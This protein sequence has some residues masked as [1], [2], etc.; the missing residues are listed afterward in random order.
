MFLTTE[1]VE[2]AFF[3]KN[4]LFVNTHFSMRAPISTYARKIPYFSYDPVEPIFTIR[5]RHAVLHLLL[6]AF[7]TISGGFPDSVKAFCA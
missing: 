3:H 4:E 1:K 7:R 6:I 2:I 5:I